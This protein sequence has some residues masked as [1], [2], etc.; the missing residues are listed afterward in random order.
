MDTDSISTPPAPSIQ[1]V[2]GSPILLVVRTA[3]AKVYEYPNFTAPALDTYY[4][5]DSLVFTNR[6]TTTATIQELEGLQYK[7]PWLRI[8]LPNQEMAWIHG[9]N[10]SFDAHAQPALADLVLYP[11]VSNLFSTS[12][13]QK[14][15][16]YQQ[17][18]PR[19]GTLP[20][21]RTLYSRAQLLK[22]S[23]E[24]HLDHYTYNHPTAAA[25]D[26]F[27][28]NDLFDGLLLHYVPEQNKHYLFRD[29]KKWRQLSEQTASLA[30][31]AFV[32]VLLA[33]YPA[34]SIGYHYYG[35]LLPWEEDNVCSLL[36]SGIHQ[37]V[38]N[39]LAIALDSNSYF[40]PE[41]QV[42]KDAVLKDLTTASDYWMPLQAVQ[43]ELDSIL[44]KNYPF[45]DTGD[46][47]ALKTKRS[48]LDAPGKHAIVLN[49]FEG[50]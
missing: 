10:I 25:T 19:T 5:E 14:I 21:F 44:Q 36:G 15:G 49:L 24:F 48:F 46:R 6:V 50:G 11:R 38:L 16:I 18:M 1:Q 27:W 9:A 23:L 13:A 7:E 30:D 12:L 42:I 2:A 35:W 22:D 28:L 47:I 26:F 8:I 20:A 4:K 39:K 40:L 33:T 45:L 17:E 32:E 3:S 37:N 31:D 43:S 34:D 29:F 41:L